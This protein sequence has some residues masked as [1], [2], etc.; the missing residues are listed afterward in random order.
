M[1]TVIPESVIKNEPIFLEPLLHGG[2]CDVELL[3]PA[4]GEELVGLAVVELGSLEQ[5]VGFSIQNIILRA[6]LIPI[7]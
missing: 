1:D 5:L 3:G 6:T 4:S 2:L 7:S